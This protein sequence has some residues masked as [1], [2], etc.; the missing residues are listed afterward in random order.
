[1]IYT[2]TL[3]PALEKRVRGRRYDEIRFEAESFRYNCAGCGIKTSLYLKQEGIQS[4]AAYICGY[5]ASSFI[6]EEMEKRDIPT[7][8]LETNVETPYHMYFIDED[9][10]VSSNYE[11]NQ[12]VSD[13]HISM[14]STILTEKMEDSATSVLEYN[15]T[16]I[17]QEAMQDFY[18]KVSEKS[19][20]CI[21]NVHPKYYASLKDHRADILL[22]DQDDF[23][24]YMGKSNCPLSETME[25]IS[26][27]LLPLAQ[28]IMYM[29]TPND[30]LVFYGNHIYRVLSMIKLTNQHIYKEAVLSAILSCL[31]KDSDFETMCKECIILSS[32]ACISDGLFMTTALTKEKIENTIHIYPI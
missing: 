15:E 4:T 17:S 10:N 9:E 32:G 1:M 28:I 19:E 13:A 29:H 12:E 27:E 16:H 6:K 18:N 14:F 3:T 2:I 5:K 24:L 21:V 20:L 11:K 22:M 25:I 30:F 26:K 23:S 7:I 8:A 31:N